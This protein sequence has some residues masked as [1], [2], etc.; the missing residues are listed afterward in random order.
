MMTKKERFIDVLRTFETPVTVSE[1]AN[2][3]VEEYP[4]ILNQINSKTNEPMTLKALAT[5]MSLKVSRGEFSELK[6][7]DSEPYRTVMYLT[8][9]KKNDLTKMEVTKDIEA[10][11]LKSKMIEDIKKSTEQDKYRLEELKNICSQLNK[12]FL[13][14]FTLHHAQSLSNS[15][16]TGRHHVDNIQLLTT[17]HVLL[18]KDGVK[19]FSIDEQKAYIKRVISVHMMIVKSIDLNLTDDVLEMLLDRLEKIY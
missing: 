3:V 7:V 19:K 1:W 8:E 5:T 17:E 6:I 16:S 11:V 13:L 18:K 12:Y 14:N 2:R 15:K 10:I 4:T 9:N